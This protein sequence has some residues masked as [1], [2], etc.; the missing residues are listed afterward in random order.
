MC[1]YTCAYTVFV[2]IYAN[3]KSEIDR[4]IYTQQNIVVA[5][6]IT[7]TMKKYTHATHPHIYKHACIYTYTHKF[8]YVFNMLS[9][10]FALTSI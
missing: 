10:C 1:I 7:C 8:V 5:I 6:I 4:S 2:T 9:S 3:D